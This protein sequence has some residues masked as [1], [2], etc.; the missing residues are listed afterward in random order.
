MPIAVNCK[1]VPLAN[2]ELAGVT[3]REVSTACVTVSVAAPEIE[4]EVAVSVAVPAAAPVARPPA[5]IVATEVAEELHTA[6]A[7]KFCVVP[8]L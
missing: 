1:V 7:V 6:V 5:E 2:D 4:P 3:A 8:L